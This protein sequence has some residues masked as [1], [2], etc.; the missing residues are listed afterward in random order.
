MNRAVEKRTPPPT[1]HSQPVGAEGSLISGMRGRA[2]AALT[3]T[4]KA[5]TARR[6]EPRVLVM[7][8]KLHRWAGADPGRRFDELANLVYDPAFLVVAW[9]GFE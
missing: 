7:Q 8:K 9:K 2:E 6:S 3:A 5:S 1:G 4:G